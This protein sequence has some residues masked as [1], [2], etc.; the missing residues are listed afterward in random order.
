MS[1]TNDKKRGALFD[2][3]GVIIDTEGIYSGFWSA[4][5][6]RFPTGIPH[7]AQSI[8][9]MNLQ[10]ILGN[11]FPTHVQAQVQQMLM[12]FQADMKYDYFPGAMDFVRMLRDNGFAVAIVTSSDQQK[13]NELYRQH[14]EFESTFDTV[15]TGDMVTHA[16]PHPECYQL[17]ARLI[18]ADL[19]DCIVFED[20]VN[21][22]KAGL[23]SGAKVVGLTTTYGPEVVRPLCH[24]MTGELSNLTLEMLP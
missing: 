8:K 15:I 11:H 23:A 3:D 1:M 13:M 20:S 21:G 6:E 5:D 16:K 22:L 17:A 7:F 12:Q 4:I 14:H 10:E 24:V 9:G 19:D 18:G 2:L